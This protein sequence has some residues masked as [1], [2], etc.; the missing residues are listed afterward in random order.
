MADWT[1]MRAQDFDT[2]VPLTLFDSPP[3]TRSPVAGGDAP[4][5][6]LTLLDTEE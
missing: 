4:D 3:A 5:D 6:L 1:R 2:R